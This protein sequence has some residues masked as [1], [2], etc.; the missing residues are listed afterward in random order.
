MCSREEFVRPRAAWSRAQHTGVAALV[1]SFPGRRLVGSRVACLG[2][3]HH[4]DLNI[5]SNWHGQ[6]VMWLDSCG[7]EP[8]TAY[9]GLFF[10]RIAFSAVLDLSGMQSAS[11]CIPPSRQKI[12]ACLHYPSHPQPTNVRAWCRTSCALLLMYLADPVSMHATCAA[13]SS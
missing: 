8:C 3:N 4:L 11:K 2:C 9:C 10:L 13:L 6:G 7:L 5:A 12:D 1:V